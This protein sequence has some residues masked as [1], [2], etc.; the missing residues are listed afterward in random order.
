MQYCDRLRL[1]MRFPVGIE[2]GDLVIFPNTAGCLVPFLES[3]SHQLPLARNLVVNVD[4][5]ETIEL[6]DIDRKDGI[7]SLSTCPNCSGWI[8]AAA[9]LRYRI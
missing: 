6:D 8:L 1:E 3:R 4:R 2:R 9:K 5:S 7:P